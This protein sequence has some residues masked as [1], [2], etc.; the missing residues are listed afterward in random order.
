[1]L[2]QEA[3]RNVV[4]ADCCGIFVGSRA[5]KTVMLIKALEDSFRKEGRERDR[6]VGCEGRGWVLELRERARYVAQRRTD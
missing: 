6:F 5:F 2:P 3:A 1:M 4:R